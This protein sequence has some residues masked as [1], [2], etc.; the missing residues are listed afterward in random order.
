MSGHMIDGKMVRKW[1]FAHLIKSLDG[2][3]HPELV[4]VEGFSVDHALARLLEYYPMVPRG[5]WELIEELDAEHEVGAL[6]RTLPLLPF[7]A[8]APWKIQ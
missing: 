8:I 7:G 1:L 3:K 5:K 2:S 4:Q 6:G